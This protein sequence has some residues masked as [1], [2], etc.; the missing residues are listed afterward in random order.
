MPAIPEA[1]ILKL[2]KTKHAAC[3]NISGAK[4]GAFIQYVCCPSCHSIY[5]WKECTIHLPDD[6]VVSKHCTF[7]KFP[8]HPQLHHRRACGRIL[9][10]KIKSSKGKLSLYPHLIYCYKSIIDSLQEMV[11][12]PGF[13]ER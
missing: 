9:M 7:V 3:S 4:G 10:K 11:S 12:K 5:N 8:S 2:P 1:F 13:V 6:Q